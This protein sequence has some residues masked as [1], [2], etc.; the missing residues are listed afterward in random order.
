LAPPRNELEPE[1][2]V[3]VVV[4]NLKLRVVLAAAAAAALSLLHFGTLGHQSRVSVRACQAPLLQL[5][6]GL[7][8]SISHLASRISHVASEYNIYLGIYPLYCRYLLHLDVHIYNI[9]THHAVTAATTERSHRRY[10]SRCRLC[11]GT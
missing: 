1:N 6:H 4:N 10:S 11:Q 8:S 3:V 7:M 5:R 9:S 2:M